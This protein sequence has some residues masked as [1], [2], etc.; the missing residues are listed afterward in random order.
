MKLEKLHIKNFKS[1]VD[2]EIIKPNPF[3]VFAGPN[4]AGKS[5]IF[6]ALE[7]GAGSV[8]FVGGYHKIFGSKE[9]LVSR[10]ISDDIIEFS[11]TIDPVG[12]WIKTYDFRD[13]SFGMK[14]GEDHD[15]K[16]IKHSGIDNFWLTRFSRIFIGNRKELKLFL[17]DDTNLVLDGSNLERVLKR[18]LEDEN[19]R[20]DISEYLEMFLPGFRQK[21]IH[22]DTLSGNDT[23][24]IYEKC[25]NKPF[26][27]DLI[28]DG[29]YNILCLLTA[30]F[31]SDEPQFLCIV[32]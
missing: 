22:S 6:E 30:L 18:L 14:L 10:I 8:T 28:S 25:I 27:K 11:F 24:L 9:D 31:Q 17:K 4:G 1:L 2:L 32:Y 16:N 3:T 29:T 13:L 23:I 19:K 20:E 5:N 21:E 7:F 15:L 12:T 26:T